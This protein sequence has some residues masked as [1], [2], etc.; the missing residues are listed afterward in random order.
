MAIPGHCWN[1]G[2][3]N[4]SLIINSLKIIL[5]SKAKTVSMYQCII[6]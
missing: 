5:L 3:W 2:K 4:N 6:D 1:D